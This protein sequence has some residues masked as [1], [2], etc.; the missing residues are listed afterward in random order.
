MEFKA[1]GPIE[2]VNDRLVYTPSAPKVKQ[3]LALLVMRTNQI[4]R[5]ESIIDELWGD[6]APR[7]A[8]TT[9]QTYIYQ[10]RKDFVVELGEELGERFIVTTPPGYVLSVPEDSLDIRVFEQLADRAHA[11]TAVGDAEGTARWA[12]AALQVWR[13]APL[14]DVPCGRV[15]QDY[16]SSLEEKRVSTQEL[17]VRAAMNLERYRDLITDL[18]SLVMEYPFNEWLH[19]QLVL[20][21]NKAG[22]RVDALHAYQKVRTLLR[23]EL[24]LDPSHDLQHAQQEVLRSSP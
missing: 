3:V 15:L 7:T 14:A 6:H 22:R 17:Y 13:G 9:A 24:G 8:V 21:L 16:V 5:L 10:L 23:D 1:L 11:C 12:K 20:A 18:R 4:V 19:A 2:V